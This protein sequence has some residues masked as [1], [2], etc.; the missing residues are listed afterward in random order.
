MVQAEEG[1]PGMES[2]RRCG[3]DPTGQESTPSHGPTDNPHGGNMSTSQSRRLTSQINVGL[4]KL[5]AEA[6]DRA[7][8]Q[9]NM[10][11][12]AYLRHLA[13][14]AVDVAT[15]TK[16]RRYRR[17][18]SADIEAVAA[19]VCELGR[20]TGS[21]IQ[22]SK[23]LRQIGARQHHADVEAVLADLRHRAIQAAAVVEQ[24]SAQR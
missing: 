12:A 22:L 6:I 5:E 3:D 23:S 15:V 10:S 4:A 11:R 2:R 14:E 20:A 18:T 16:P 21:A 8:R 7:A 9:A 24:L 19:L 17:L 13:L 1:E